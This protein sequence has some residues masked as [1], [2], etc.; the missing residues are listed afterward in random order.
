MYRLVVPFGKTVYSCVY[1]RTLNEIPLL[2]KELKWDTK[3]TAISIRYKTVGGPDTP[4]STQYSVITYMGKG[5]EKE[6]MY[7]YVT[8]SLWC[9][10]ET[11][12]TL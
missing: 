10:P 9:T 1:N 8:D 6:W 12:T 7:I 3:L 4:S 11:N 2:S 5:S